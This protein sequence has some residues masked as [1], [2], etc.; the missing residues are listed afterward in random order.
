MAATVKGTAHLFGISAG[1]ASITKATVVSFDTTKQ[2]NNRAQTVNEEGNQIE[3]RFDDLHETGSI[4]I[5]IQ[6]GY[7]EPAAAS[8]LTYDEVAY[9]ITS[10][11]RQESSSDFVQ[12]TLTI[13]KKANISLS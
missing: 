8:V 10:V 12:L 7:T 5:R 2:H 1:V 11:Q 4:T 6:T 9:L 3:D 13:E